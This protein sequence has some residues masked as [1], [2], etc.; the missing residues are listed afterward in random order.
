MCATVNKQRNAILNALSPPDLRLLEP[1]LRPVPLPFRH[2]MQSANRRV[3]TVYFLESGLGSV[4]AVGGGRRQAEVGVIGREG[5]TGLPVVLRA[6]RAP[7]E[8]FMQVE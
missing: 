4:V 2:R 3:Q 8:I 1:H 7:C 5:M 6:E